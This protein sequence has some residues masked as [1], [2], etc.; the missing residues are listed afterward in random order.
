[1]KILFLGSAHFGLPSLKGLLESRHQV[2]CVITQPDKHAGRGLPV[3]STQIKHFA[4][5]KNIPVFQPQNIN[6]P[7]S[8]AYLKS[9][10]PD[11]MVII[12]Y[13]Q[14][15]SSEVL[16]IPRIFCMNLHASLLPRYRGAG[17]INWAI[18]NGEETTGVTVMKVIRKMDAGP[19]ILQKK[20]AISQDD[21]YTSLEVRLAEAGGPLLL[22]A[23]NR[24][25][26]GNFSLIQQN[27]S[28]VT[29]APKLKKEDGR[30]NWQE[31]NLRIYNL[32]RGCIVWP[33]AFTLYRGKLLKV[34]KA[35]PVPA[36]AKQKAEPG[37]V[38]AV[39]KLG[40]TV[41]SGKGNLLIEEVQM[42]SKRRMMIKDFLAGH[43]LKAGETLGK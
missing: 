38:V 43:R 28:A 34:Y 42:E 7:D 22:D 20:I 11:L 35:R 32:V 21:D 24:I 8:V 30:I 41:A 23:V 1:M 17:P 26:D 2:S 10:A 16:S 31:E 19:L 39:T 18:I 12:A 25:E 9:L 29:Y 5:E 37:Q 27:E 36:P 6:S 14:L 3:V 13:G 40:I 4:L 15:L 33:G